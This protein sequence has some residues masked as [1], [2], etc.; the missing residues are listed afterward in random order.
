MAIQLRRVRPRISGV[1]ENTPQS[2]GL[3]K[4]LAWAHKHGKKP[5]TRSILVA[6]GTHPVA[7]K[8]CGKCE[9][10]RKS[11]A[12]DKSFKGSLPDWHKLVLKGGTVSRAWTKHLGRKRA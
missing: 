8:A 12:C 5:S 9:S 1:D 7:V 3:N 10:C 11:R 2:L 6:M 4:L